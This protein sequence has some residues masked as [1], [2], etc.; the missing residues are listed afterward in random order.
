MSDLPIAC[1]LSPD[2]RASRRQELLAG[3]VADALACEPLA[4]GLRLTLPAT[5]AS[6]ERIARTIDVER[7]CCRFLEFVLVV[8]PAGAYFELRVSGPPGTAGFLALLAGEAGAE[9]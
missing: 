9:A 6:L 1:T 4:S 7:Q 8:P 3:L 2:E 5:S